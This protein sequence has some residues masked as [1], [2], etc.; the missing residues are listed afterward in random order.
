M[1]DGAHDLGALMGSAIVFLKVVIIIMDS[2]Y[3][4]QKLIIIL[5]SLMF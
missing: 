5:L 3:I 1:A 2:V 4:Y